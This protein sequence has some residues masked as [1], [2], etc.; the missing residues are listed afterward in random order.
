MTDF[1]YNVLETIQTVFFVY[2]QRKYN[3]PHAQRNPY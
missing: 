1:D 2:H 3:V